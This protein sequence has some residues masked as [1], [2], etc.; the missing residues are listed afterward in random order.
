M[1]AQTVPQESMG[2]NICSVYQ[3]TNTITGED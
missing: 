3:I 1:S 2:S